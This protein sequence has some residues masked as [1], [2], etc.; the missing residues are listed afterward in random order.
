MP[1]PDLLS[2]LFEDARTVLP[3]T[4][5]NPHP[6]ACMNGTCQC[7][8]HLFTRNADLIPWEP[9]KQMKQ[10]QFDRNHLNKTIVP[11]TLPKPNPSATPTL[12]ELLQTA[13]TYL[14]LHTGMTRAEFAT[15]YQEGGMVAS[16]RITG[17]EYISYLYDNAAGAASF[18]KV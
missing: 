4:S 1:K 9:M 11:F 3:A 17:M 7:A 13:Y 6:E 10:S 2:H 18:E 15:A 5:E 16:G 12:A 14:H 8:F